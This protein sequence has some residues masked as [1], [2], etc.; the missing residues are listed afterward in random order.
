MPEIRRKFDAGFR[1]GAVRIVRESGTPI[2]QV[3]RDWGINEGTLGNWVIHERR[4]SEPTNGGLLSEDERAEL[5]R[6]RRE[7]AELVMERD[8]KRSVALWVKEA[9][10]RRPGR[11]SSQ[12]R[13]PSTPCLPRLPAVPWASRRPG[14]RSGE[15]DHRRHGGDAAPTSSR[16]SGP[17][18][19]P[20]G[21]PTA[22]RGS[23]STCTRTAGG[24]RRTPSRRSCATTAGRDGRRR[25][26]RGA[27]H[28]RPRHPCLG[29]R[30][31]RV[32]ERRPATKATRPTCGSPCDLWFPALL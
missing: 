32:G 16:R 5:A 8:V 23:G 15:N 9:M 28:T 14:T 21:S 12:P 17:P 19:R 29:S 2:A 24:P 10:G 22:P 26:E 1:A 11:P 25:G 30:P 31:W 6:L 13:E 20:P 18:S 7:N 3:A 27:A 4:A